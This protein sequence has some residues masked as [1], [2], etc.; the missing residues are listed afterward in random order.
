MFGSEFEYTDRIAKL[1]ERQRLEDY[2]RYET[3]E[4]DGEPYVGRR[5]RADREG[6]EET[7]SNSFYRD[8]RC[9]AVKIGARD[10]TER[11]EERVRSGDWQGQT[12]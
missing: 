9:A 4:D 8:D 7:V 1:H 10:M 11:G 5:D 2:A 3:G 6:Y 12:G